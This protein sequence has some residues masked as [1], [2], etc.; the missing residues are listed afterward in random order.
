MVVKS[1]CSVA[2][3]LQ[4]Y[5]CVTELFQTNLQSES[6]NDNNLFRKWPCLFLC[7]KTGFTRLDL[8]LALIL[9]NVV[10]RD[11]TKIELF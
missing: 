3:C 9:F 6:A 2:K 10:S 7:R 4:Q 5:S 1:C 8:S 11:Q